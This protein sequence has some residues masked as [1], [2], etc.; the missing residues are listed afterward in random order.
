MVTFPNAKINLGLRIRSKRPDGYH[1]IESIMLPIAWNDILEIVPGRK[2]LQLHLSGL[3]LPSCPNEDNLVLKALRRLEAETGIVLPPSEIYL[4]K[5]IPFGAG[6]GGGS[7]DAAFALIAANELYN[8]GIDKENLAKIASKVGADCAFFIY[9]KPQIA[10]GIGDILNDV[11]V[12]ILNSFHLLVIK[13]QSQ[14]VSTKAAYAGVTPKGGITA[15]T[16]CSELKIPVEQW[17]ARGILINDFEESIFPLRPEI[18]EVKDKLLS[19]GAVYAS[20]SG[21]GASVYGLFRNENLASAAVDKFNNC[22]VLL[23]KINY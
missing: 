22:D 5:S 2:G 15:E 8:L 6:T 21:S 20:M 4:H 18:K 11:D 17:L 9:N 23:Q 1:N 19:N 14:S 16:L 10:S 13:P 12:S 7:A 3:E